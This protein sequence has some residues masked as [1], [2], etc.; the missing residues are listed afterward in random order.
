MTQ[1]IGDSEGAKDKISSV[2]KLFEEKIA[3]KAD[4]SHDFRSF[5]KQQK[6]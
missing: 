6:Q 5:L 4:K 3:K 2:M 1:A